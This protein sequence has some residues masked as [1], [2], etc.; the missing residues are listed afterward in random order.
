LI[1]AKHS[2]DL[3]KA[4]EASND[5]LPHAAMNLGSGQGMGIR[6]PNLVTRL[7][8]DEQY[9]NFVLYRLDGNGGFVG[10]S[11]HGSL[12]DALWQ[13]KKEFG[14]DWKPTTEPDCA[15]PASTNRPI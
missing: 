13:V 9:G 15:D 2:L 12:A 14:I 6:P 7:V 11:W 1:V 10:D 5:C 8:I 3:P 4:L